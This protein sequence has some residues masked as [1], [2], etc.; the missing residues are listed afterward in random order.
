MDP[1]KA[2]GPDDMNPAFYQQH[3]DVVEEDVSNFVTGCLGEVC[4]P[5]H[6]NDVS[7]VLIPKKSVPE[8]FAELRPIA[9]C[10]VVYKILAKMIAICI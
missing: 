4:F 5:P 8:S 2:L 6:L 9:L 7:I 1:D 3:W 10:K